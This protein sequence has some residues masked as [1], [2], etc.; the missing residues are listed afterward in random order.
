MVEKINGIEVVQQ[1][2]SKK[3]FDILNGLN[4]YTLTISKG[5]NDVGASLSG[6]QIIGGIIDGVTNLEGG[7]FV[8]GI[9]RLAGQN[10]LAKIFVSDKVSNL[11]TGASL[12]NI[13]TNK[14][15]LKEIFLGKQSVAAIIS[16]IALDPSI[17]GEGD[18]SAEG[19]TQLST[20]ELELLKKITPN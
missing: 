8:K 5:M 11:F 10:R 1:I 9:A 4:Q 14:E 15:K 19:Q 16:N 18:D 13:R 20:K 7:K 12:Q 3:D 2:L 6:A 17:Q